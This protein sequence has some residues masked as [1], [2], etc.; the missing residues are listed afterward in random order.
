MVLNLPS[1]SRLVFLAS[2]LPETATIL[3]AA[4]LVFV[5]NEISP[6]VVFPVALV[7]L[8]GVFLAE[9]VLTFKPILNFRNRQLSTFLKRY[10]AMAEDSLNAETPDEVTLRTS[11]FLLRNRKRWKFWR[12]NRILSVDHVSDE[13]DYTES[14]LELEYEVGQ[15]C[16]G[17]VIDRNKPFVAISPK[18]ET[19]WDSGW[20]TTDF[21]DETTEHLNVMIGAPIYRPSDEEKTKPIGVFLVD[22]EDNLPAIL[23]LEDEESL[24]EIEKLDTGIVRTA[25]DHARKVGILL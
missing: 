15:G 16:P 6:W 2:L 17:R 4:Y 25:I 11:I 9:Y 13:A 10:L 24:D 19:S 1:Q 21:Q 23:N 20:G 7:L 22:S 14:E 5:T 12:D 18:H 8:I 3:F